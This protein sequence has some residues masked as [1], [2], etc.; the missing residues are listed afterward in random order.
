MTVQITPELTDAQ[1]VPRA[2]AGELAAFE[3]LTTRHEQR[4]Y[5]LA[6]RM[7]RHE[8]DAED[9]TQQ[10]FLSALEN[11]KGIH[12]QAEGFVP[13]ASSD[14]T[15]KGQAFVD[16]ALP[17]RIILPSPPTVMKCSLS[18]RNIKRT[19]VVPNSLDNTSLAG[20]ICVTGLATRPLDLRD[21][22]PWR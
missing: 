22:R 12:D 6:F 5:S 8:Q 18:A 20:E 14:L 17:V 19:N 4:V 9:V 1:L 2:K 13:R 7:L 3:A 16:A 11:F 15:F 21:H 10:T